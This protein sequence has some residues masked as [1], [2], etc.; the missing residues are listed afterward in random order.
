M[1]ESSVVHEH[2]ALRASSSVYNQPFLGKFL[3]AG[4]RSSKMPRFP[5]WAAS[6]ALICDDF[7]SPPPNPQFDVN[8]SFSKNYAVCE[9]LVAA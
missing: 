7:A 3:P 2:G 1:H 9:R 5:C 6:I 8:R 4:R